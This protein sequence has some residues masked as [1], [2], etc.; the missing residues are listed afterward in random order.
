[1]RKEINVWRK[2]LELVRYLLKK[3][4]IG[5][6]YFGFKKYNDGLCSFPNNKRETLGG[7]LSM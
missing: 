4:K 6:I 2:K 1:V 7:Q 3:A 5:M